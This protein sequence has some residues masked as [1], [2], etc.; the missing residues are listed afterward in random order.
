[1]NE[2]K[3]C[4]VLVVVCFWTHLFHNTCSDIFK[5][6]VCEKVRKYTFLFLLQWSPSFKINKCVS[7]GNVYKVHLLKK[8]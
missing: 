3:N 6:F 5:H 8:L 4:C 7:P 2:V 1:M